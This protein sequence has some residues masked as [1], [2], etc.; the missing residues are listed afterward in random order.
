MRT[1]KAP[2]PRMSRSLL[3]GLICAATYLLFLAMLFAVY[4]PPQYDLKADQVSPLTITASRDV[5]DSYTTQQLIDEAVA[6][7]PVSY[8]LDDTVQ[9]AVIDDFNAFFD[10]IVDACSEDAA[11]AEQARARL[12]ADGLT[13]DDI[14]GLS[15][16]DDETLLSVRADTLTIIDELLSSRVTDDGVGEAVAKLGRELTDMELYDQALVGLVGRG[17]AS[18]LR[19]NMLIDQLTTE[20]NRQKAAD[21]V[22][23]IVFIKGRNIVRQG[24]IITPAQIAMLESLGMLK[25]TATFDVLMYLGVALIALL[26]LIMVLAYALV[27]EQAVVRDT[28]TVALISAIMLITCGACCLTQYV[29]QFLVPVTLGVMLMALLIR[30]RFALVTNGALAVLAGLINA[31]VNGSFSTSLIIVMMTT[32]ISGTLCAALL[33]GK[34]QRVIVL[35]SGLLAAGSNMLTTLAVGLITD[36]NTQGALSWSLWSAAGGLLAAVLCIGLQPAL[37]WLFNLVTSAKLMELSSPNHPLIRR[38]ILEASGTYHHSIIVANLAEAAANDIGANG[39]L[40]RVGAY[41][42]DIGKLKRPLYFKENQ[43]GDNPHDRTDPLVSAA[44][45]TAHTT[46][47]VELAM[48]YRMPKQILD[49]IQQHHGDTP[50][51]YFYDRAMRQSGDKNIDIND[52][53]YAGP[54]PQTRE[55]AVVMLA[56]TIEAAARTASDRTSEGLEKL[57]RQ[58]IRAKIDDG[59]LNDSP[60]TLSDIEK[61]T[62]AFVTVLSGVFHQRVKYPEI[63]LPSRREVKTRAEA[64]DIA[65][66]ADQDTGAVGDVAA[67][68]AGGGDR[69]A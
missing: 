8:M 21:Q 12:R 65:P 48:K 64:P 4:R 23:R 63:K 18:L 34:T 61:V 19:P 20:A 10:A 58:L 33:K 49:I 2:R 57:I 69:H 24:E 7:V 50:V 44:I 31:G 53:R 28:R 14:A 17:A 5:E 3:N 66:A 43:I 54:R 55:A 41:Y 29:N 9:S 67:A 26:A 30:P 39:L 1:R 59:Q 36:S 60:M 42:H 16:L 37:E 22:E 13:Q 46:D 11:I 6:A 27:F 47:G 52:F 62:K 68:M 45:L 15:A 40:A 56:D 38:M 35:L 51:L 32:L 25:G